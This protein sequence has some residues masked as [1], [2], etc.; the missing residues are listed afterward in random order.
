M[1]SYPSI[2]YHNSGIEGSKVWVFDK[3]D[4]NNL[5]FEYSKN[6]GFYKFG[7]R[8]NLISK[9]DINYGE[10]ITIFLDKYSKE[11]E[12]R[13]K[14]L[15]PNSLSMTVFGEYFGENSFSGIHQEGDTM[16]VT[17][18]DIINY[19]KGFIPVSKYIE[20]F[21]DLHITPLLEITTFEDNLIES[22]RENDYITEL[23]EGVVVKGEKKKKGE[24]IPWM[25]KI[26]TWEWL[27]KVKSK[28][29][30]KALLKEVNNDK[31]ILE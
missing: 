16:D 30:E 12:Y 5:R 11:L 29:G 15:Y 9:D 28:Y 25:C 23:K 18:F 7:T 8:T 27:D 22:I 14:H 17:I 3:P 31:T 2:P 13:F 10:G 4:G 6:R 20:Q 21:G 1:Q 24:I 26:K 19:K